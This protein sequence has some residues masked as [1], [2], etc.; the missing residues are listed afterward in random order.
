MLRYCVGNHGPITGAKNNRVAMGDF[1]KELRRRNI[2]K[3]ATVYIIVGWLLVQIAD[4][5][6]ENFSAP[7]WVMKMFIVFMILGF[8]VAMIFAWAFEMTADGFKLEKNVDRGVSMTSETGQRLNFYII[9]ALV[10]ALAVSVW[11]NVGDDTTDDS[12]GTIGETVEGTAGGSDGPGAGS[13]PSRGD[14]NQGAP[15]HRPFR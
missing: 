8:P 15:G 3:V 1:L 13:L 5:A 11:L 10:L 9:G 6:A 12:E 4:I 7:G 14:Q 2:F